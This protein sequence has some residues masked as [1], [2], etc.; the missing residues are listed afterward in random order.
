MVS[1]LVYGL[2]KMGQLNEFDSWAIEASL[3]TV[4]V[5]TGACEIVHLDDSLWELG[6]SKVEDVN[7]DGDEKRLLNFYNCDRSKDLEKYALVACRA[8]RREDFGRSESE[9]Y[10]HFETA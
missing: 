8:S 6:A 2:Y 1:D 10:Y 9:D 3:V 4:G 7:L 5:E